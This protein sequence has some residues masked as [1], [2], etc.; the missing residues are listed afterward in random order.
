MIR[1]LWIALGLLLPACASEVGRASQRAREFTDAARRG[2]QATTDALT[3]PAAR[4]H[5]LDASQW[6]FEERLD[7]VGGHVDGNW[8]VVV[9]RTTAQARRAGIV[10]VLLRRVHSEWLVALVDFHPAELGLMSSAYPTDPIPNSFTIPMRALVSEVWRNDESI[11]EI[12]PGKAE[13]VAVP[14]S[15]HEDRVLRKFTVDGAHRV[16]I[17]AKTSDATRPSL[18]IGSPEGGGR[19]AREASPDCASIER[20]LGYGTYLLSV[21][22]AQPATVRVEIEFQPLSA[23]ER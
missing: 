23:E 8:A 22:A 3:E 6:P 15:G 5:P 10:P 19:P 12:H 1:L 4:T 16:R 18:Y 7:A 11:R 21:G 9:L 13:D 14:G 20:P 17:T 2:D